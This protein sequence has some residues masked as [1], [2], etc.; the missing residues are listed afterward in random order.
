VMFGEM[1]SGE[2]VFACA[3]HGMETFLAM[4]TK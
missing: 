1:A 2:H 4:E 3:K